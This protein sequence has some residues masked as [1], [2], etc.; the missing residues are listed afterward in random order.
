MAYEHDGFR[1]TMDTLREKHVL[2]ELAREGDPPWFR[3]I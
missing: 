2:E 3:E 1:Q